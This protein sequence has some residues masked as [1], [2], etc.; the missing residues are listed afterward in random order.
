MR[1]CRPGTAHLHGRLPSPEDRGGGHRRRRDH[2]HHPERGDRVFRGDR[3]QGAHGHHPGDRRA[4]G[5]HPPERDAH[6]L[7]PERQARGPRKARVGRPRLRPSCHLSHGEDRAHGL[8]TPV[9]GAPGARHRELELRGEPPHA[10]PGRQRQGVVGAEP[11]GT[12]RPRGHGPGRQ[13][14]GRNR[15]RHPLQLRL[16]SHEPRGLAD[17]RRLPGI[18]VRPHPGDFRQCPALLPAG[19][20]RRPETDARGSRGEDLRASHH[21]ADQGH[22]PRA[23]GSGCAD[24]PGRRTPPG[25]RRHRPAPVRDRPRHR[26]A[27]QGD[28]RGRALEAR[29]ELQEAVGPA[30]QGAHGRGASR[31]AR[32]ALR[33]PDH[34][35]RRLPGSGRPGRRGRG[36]ARAADETRAARAFHGRVAPR[37]CQRRD[38]LCP[39]EAAAR[40]VGV[41]GARRQPVPQADGPLRPGDGGPHPRDGGRDAGGAGG[42]DCAL[43]RCPAAAPCGAG[44]AR[45]LQSEPRWQRCAWYTAAD[46]PRRG[47]RQP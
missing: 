32:G 18:R 26:A 46:S 28:G 20:W 39:R 45:R 37:L 15:A 17:R 1:L 29:D 24:H 35:L 30:P 9:S 14:S 11:A 2:D 33:D 21:R 41:R 10:R 8:E 12:A 47:R 19:L 36:R 3:R 43:Q 4:G 34:A 44:I 7:R 16:P 13:I 5:T 27:G 22:R 23:R 31:G 42:G 25:E 38:R 40:G 6:P